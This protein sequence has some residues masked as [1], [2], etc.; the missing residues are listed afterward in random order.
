MRK[1]TQQAV[2]AFY[3]GRNYA[4]GNTSVTSNTEETRLFLHGNLIAKRTH[5]DNALYITNAGWSS[6]TTKERLNGLA[7]VNISQ[8]NWTWYLNGKEWSGDWIKV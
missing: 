5:S 3:A 1:T 8:K 6:N 2:N 7:G 4:S